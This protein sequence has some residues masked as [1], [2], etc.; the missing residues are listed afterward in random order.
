MTAMIKAR[1]EIVKHPSIIFNIITLLIVVCGWVYVAGAR[2]SDMK[3]IEQRV[4]AVEERSSSD[5]DIL[6]GMQSDLTW[7]RDKLDK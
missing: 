1:K 7:I 5:H 2:A 3:N 6:I 4:G